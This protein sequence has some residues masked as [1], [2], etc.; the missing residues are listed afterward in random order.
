MVVLLITAA[1]LVGLGFLLVKKILPDQTCF[2]NRRNQRELEIDCGGPC[3]PCELKN[4]KTIDI[5]WARAA[6]VRPLMYDVVAEIRNSNEVLYSSNLEY[7]F[8]LFDEFGLVARKTGRTFI[9]PQEK[10]YVVEANL[11]TTREP[12]RVEFKVLGVDW[13][14][15][16]EEIPNLIIE[17]RDYKIIE[18]DGRK[19]SVIESGILNRTSFDFREAEIIFVVFDGAGNLLGANRV[20]IENLFSGSR[21]SVKSIWPEEL[22]GGVAVIKIQPRVNIFDPGVILQPR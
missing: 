5:F 14:V 8:T 9:F 3:A 16:K 12:V 1:P 10:T 4:P 22:M 11:N 13:Q 19:Q 2:D 21:Q 15:K 7:E 6:S 18:T 17:K 20:V